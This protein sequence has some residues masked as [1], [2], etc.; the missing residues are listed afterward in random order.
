M[1]K[2]FL[3]LIAILLFASCQK[4]ILTENVVE[5]IATSNEISIR[6]SKISIC[7]KTSSP[8]KPWLSITITAN[9][10]KAHLAHGDVVPDAD[11]DGYTKVNPCGVGAQND[12]DDNNAAVN[13]GVAE[14]CNNGVDDNCDGQIDENCGPPVD[15]CETSLNLHFYDRTLF[16]N[17]LVAS[18]LIDFSTNYDG[19]PVSN[20]IADFSLSNWNWNG[21]V[22][23][24]CRSYWNGF[25]Y[26]SPNQYITVDFPSGI[27]KKAGF[28]MGP[29]YGA[30]G[31]YT[32]K[33]YSGSCI[34]TYEQYIRTGIVG[35]FGINLTTNFIDTIKM[36]LDSDHL[37]VDNFQ[38]GN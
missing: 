33:V 23:S 17:T 29:F 25:I 15:A 16:T 38:F 11:G 19:S 32:V 13:S 12:C 21:I 5:E 34:Y 7:H 1:K 6:S 31:N 24:N 27:Y 4:E 20:P 30:S 8:T 36:K 2:I 26:T 37:V 3:P 10:L 14:I 18:Q 22:F 9:S 28:V 35:Y